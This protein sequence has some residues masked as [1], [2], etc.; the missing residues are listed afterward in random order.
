MLCYE[1][2]RDP[3]ET[4]VMNRLR[5][6][7]CSKPAAACALLVLPALLP[8][9]PPAAHA[10]DPGRAPFEYITRTWGIGEGLPQN[11]VTALVQ[12]RDGY[13]WLG[14]Y[15]GLVR[16]DGVNFGIINKWNTPDLKNDRITSLHE[17]SEG[18]LWVGTYGGGV[19]SLRAGEWRNYTSREGLSSDFVTSVITDS[20]GAVWV[21]TEDGLNRISGET[22][23]TFST[24][25][26]LAGNSITSLALGSGG[27]LLIGAL[28]GGLS[29]LESVESEEFKPLE[30]VPAR[31]V[32][33]VLADGE[34]RLWVGA[35]N[36]LHVLEDGGVRRYSRENG[37][38]GNSVQALAMD[39]N[40]DIWIGLAAGGLNLLRGGELLDLTESGRFP[41]DPVHAIFEDR[42]GSI[43]VGTDAGGLTQIKDP[44]V[45][46]ITTRNGLPGD[47]TR[48]VLGDSEG[49]LYV[50]TEASGLCLVRDGS[51]T[52][53]MNTSSGLPGNRIRC[54]YEDRS[55]VIWVGTEGSGLAG[56]RGGA[57]TTY[58]TRDGLSSD[59]I[60]AIIED[61]SGTLWIGTTRGL[62]R[63][64]D[65]VVRAYDRTTNL[66][67]SHIR[68]LFE[69]DQGVLHVGT[70]EGLIKFYA[71][72][73][74]PLYLNEDGIEPDILSIHE[75]AAGLLWIG[76]A[77]NGLIRY[78]GTEVTTYT[79]SEGLLDNHIFSIVED[80]TGGLW[81]S[82]YIGVFRIPRDQIEAMLSGAVRR[83]TPALYDEAEGFRNRQCTFEGEPSACVG[84]GGRLCYPTIDGVAVLDPAG[85]R[86]GGVPPRAI[87]EGMTA[88]NMPV[89]G[90]GADLKQSLH[91]VQFRFTA[92]DFLA[93]EKVRFEYRL[94]GFDEDWN[95]LSFKS[96][97]TAYYFNL[98]P[99]D[100][101]FKVRAAGNEGEWSQ[102]EA[103]L[104]FR[105]L[106][107]FYRRLQFYALILAMLAA[108]AAVVA[109]GRRKKQARPE[110]Y[111]TSA[112]AD[113][114]IEEVLPKLE[115]LMDEEKVYLDA[116]LNLQELARRAGIHYNYLSRIINEKF[117]LSYNDYVNGYRIEEAKRMLADPEHGG[118]TILDIAYE[119]GFYSK[120][121]FNTAFKK[122]TGMTPS[123]YR[124]ASKKED[125]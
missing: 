34:G 120:S 5:K 58:T 24:W 7:I 31:V 71:Q 76:T 49:N 51:V 43:W 68:T 119:T 73:P 78:E 121:V 46:M 98:A 18:A 95:S 81:M 112:L 17:D 19:S 118:K 12:T 111:S 40:G 23:A 2:S 72:S 92:L 16:F 10:L 6:H 110:K 91:V 75:G 74:L 88:D 83:F 122:I 54:L 36:G 105:I 117:G 39:G 33:A 30:D 47:E 113:E 50:G 29:V 42:D 107:P 41:A 99:G 89:G 25:N 103:S 62:N 38:S 69:S 37:L 100:Y 63:L 57:I 64:K 8:V 59:D 101:M 102:D 61:R 53:V 65:G 52:R 35:F 11:S 84:D 20:R 124:K 22:I 48:A 109:A 15:S 93:P 1:R 114:K 44:R 97:R 82:S 87:V 3:L 14:T 60:T 28:D 67:R 9:R 79:T 21:G 4:I 96:P 26:G 125:A 13:I 56:I 104:R 32:N 123:R 27:R 55:G 70:R 85:L 45:E 94:E 106:K 77:G 108:G 90:D 115:R 80:S 66:G 116:D 86:R